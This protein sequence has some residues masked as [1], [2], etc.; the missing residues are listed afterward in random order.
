MGERIHLGRKV[1]E[2]NIAG[3]GTKNVF[4]ISEKTQLCR[5]YHRIEWFGTRKRIFRSK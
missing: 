4:E 5:K 3:T 1:T 2:E